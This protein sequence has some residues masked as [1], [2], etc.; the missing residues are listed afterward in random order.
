VD[1]ECFHNS[2]KF[3]I[4]VKIEDPYTKWKSLLDGIAQAWQYSKSMN[5]N[6]FIVL[7]YPAS[8][9]RPLVVTAEVIDHL[10]T[11]SYVNAIILTEFWTDKF[12]QIPVREIFQ[13]LR[14]KSDAFIARQEKY[15]SLDLA[16]ETIREAILTISGVLRQFM[17]T[18]D[19]LINTVVGRFDLFLALAEEDKEK[20]RTAAIDLS[21]YLLVNQILFYHIYSSLTKNVPDLDEDQISSIYDLH[22]LFKK[23]T[24]INYKAVYSVDIIPY[25]PDVETIIKSVKAVI[26]AIKGVRAASIRHDLIGRIY[27]ESLPFETRKRLAAFY[28]KPIAAEILA[29]L[30]IDRWDESV[31]DPACGSGTLLV[32]AYRRKES[33][34]KESLRK[35]FL[36]EEENDRLHNL[37]VQEHLTGLDIM[38][39][40]THLTAVNLSAQNPQAITNKLRVATQNSL[41]LQGIITSKE[42]KTQGVLLKPFSRVIQETLIRPPRAKQTFFSR[43]GE[44][45]EMQGAVSPEGVGEEF[46]FH[47]VD[48]V[49]MN[50]PFSDRDKMPKDYRETLKN[51]DKLIDICGNQ[52]NYWGFFL[53]L[54]DYL[55]KKNG[56]MGVV[57]PINIFRGGA[58]QRIRDHILSNHCIRYIV[59]SVKDVAFSE[60]ANFRDVLLVSEKRKATPSDLTCLVFLKKSMKEITID[61]AKA[62]VEKIR[63]LPR[64]REYED[65]DLEVCWEETKSLM[66]QRKNLMPIVGFFRKKSRNLV[67]ELMLMLVSSNKVTKLSSKSLQ[68]AFTYRPQGLTEIVFITR[69]LEE[70]RVGR[71]F[72][73]LSKE[74]EDVIKAKV[75]VLE[76]EITIKKSILFP[77]L[78]TITGVK[79]MDITNKFDY[80]ILEPYE[81]FDMILKLSR[82]KMK[83]FDWKFFKTNVEKEK[84]HLI[85]PRRIRLDSDNTHLLSFISKQ[86]FIPGTLTWIVKIPFE[87]AKIFVLYF[88]SIFTLAQF[89]AYKSETTEEFFE[90][91]K[92]DWVLVDVLDPNKLTTEDKR[93]MHELFE[94]IKDVKF[95]SLL[96]QLKGKFWARWEIDKAICEILGVPQNRIEPFLSQIYDALYDE[97]ALF[98]G[99]V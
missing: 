88:N 68:P 67:K 77:A 18:I 8:V 47:P 69:P 49:I 73:T 84:G 52:V 27:H 3:I 42:F 70:S 10:A 6:G 96:E 59:K 56:K 12:I 28:T 80:V 36:T 64:G 31:V 22:K 54:A 55:L 83:T 60:A 99:S 35:P 98:K 20:L 57:V 65:E 91:M 90:M 76:R 58:S 13:R 43:F 97:I 95:P 5:A 92:Q 61:S 62:I 7:E 30:C 4:E 16:V 75:K 51:Y 11:Q 37:F 19:D 14:E 82:W 2:L 63:R 44:I 79:T 87:D 32:A 72:M 78:R 94:K 24:D 48:V 17:G 29:G 38:P 46:L 34:Y 50:P 41:S 25:L 45:V 71:A 33:L 66:L 23:I 21:S 1:L 9:R 40:A 89:L 86:E 15:V 26:R 39:F 74:S 53:A 85:I 93:K 81:D